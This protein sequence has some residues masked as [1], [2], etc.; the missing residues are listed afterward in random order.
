MPTVVTLDALEPDAPVTGMLLDRTRAHLLWGAPLE[1]RGGRCEI[2]FVGYDGAT[3]EPRRWVEGALDA[4]AG[5]VG[6][7]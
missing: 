7:E 2:T 5:E 4:A 3:D 6:V 1:L